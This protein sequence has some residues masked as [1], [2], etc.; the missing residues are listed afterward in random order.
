MALFDRLT[1][2]D[3][4]KIPVHQFMAA[5]SELARGRITKAQMEALFTIPALDS[6]WVNLVARFNALSGIAEKALFMHELEQV[7]ILAEHG[8]IYATAASVRTRLA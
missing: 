3:Q 7:L 8:M 2:Q 4:T 5:G 6:D 1:A